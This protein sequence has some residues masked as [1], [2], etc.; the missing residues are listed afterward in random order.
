[1]ADESDLLQL[2]SHP[3]F[4]KLSPQ[5]QLDGI[6]KYEPA[7]ADAKLWQLPEIKHKIK[8]QGMNTFQKAVDW[9]DN[10]QDNP[11]PGMQP[12]TT[13]EKIH[14]FM[15][16]LGGFSQPERISNRLGTAV[17]AGVPASLTGGPLAGIPAALSGFANPMKDASDLAIA[18]ASG[19][20][21]GIP[22]AANEAPGLKDVLKQGLKGGALTQALHML[23]QGANVGAEAVGLQK[24][25]GVPRT[26]SDFFASPTATAVG[27]VPPALS[28]WQ[29]ANKVAGSPISVSKRMRDMAVGADTEIGTLPSVAGRDTAA[30]AQ[31]PWDAARQRFAQDDKDLA[32]ATDRIRRID[33]LLAQSRADTASQVE[34]EVVG[35]TVGQEQRRQQTLQL[36]QAR[37]A[38]VAAKQQIILQ[39][40]GIKAQVAGMAYD[41]AIEE[42]K[43]LLQPS[44]TATPFPGAKR[45]SLTGRFDSAQGPRTLEQL[46]SDAISEGETNMAV[47]QHRLRE[48]NRQGDKEAAQQIDNAILVQQ[49]QNLARKGAMTQLRQQ[50]QAV[51]D[52]Q[53]IATSAR[54]IDIARKAFETQQL[55]QQQASTQGTIGAIDAQ[56]RALAG[57]APT[58]QV[59][60]ISAVGKA[61]EKSLLQARN[62]FMND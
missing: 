22:Q 32:D 15:S 41:Q 17:A 36:I 13:G 31:S 57:S 58:P 42:E 28:Q 50:Q 7:F 14:H 11:V 60:A 40:A 38:A 9:M 6:K 34:K 4:E 1:M 26:L 30:A 61:E 52:Q 24:P 43:A 10:P 33:T 35:S 48:A 25:S 46:Q 21:P 45:N 19:G 23:G 20:I 3:E 59:R 49:K 51:K 18:V 47:L 37:D 62:Q 55:N 8:R 12:R 29:V 53:D 16:T 39:K 54:D 5:E 44:P 2:L 27:S 56:K